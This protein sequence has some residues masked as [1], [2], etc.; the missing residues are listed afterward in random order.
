MNP[1]IKSALEKLASE[2]QRLL[3]EKARIETD[4][5][6]VI[7]VKN[8]LIEA[9]D[10]TKPPPHKKAPAG[11]VPE[12]ILGVLTPNKPLGNR[13]IREAIASTGYRYSLTPLHVTKHLIRLTKAKKVKRVGEGATCGYVLRKR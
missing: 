12:K 1:A 9:G 13:G 2:E 4:L 10:S 6:K 5:N 3:S 7:A 11:M 8:A